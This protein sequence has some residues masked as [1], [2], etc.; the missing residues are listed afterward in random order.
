MRIVRL[1]A[2]ALTLLVCT[3]IVG[4]WGLAAQVSSANNTVVMMDNCLPGD[5]GYSAA[6]G[7]CAQRPNLGDVPAA[8]FGQLLISPLISG[9]VGHPA[10]RNEP[11]H[12]VIKRGHALRVTNRGGRTHTLTKVENS[13]AVRS[14]HSI[15]R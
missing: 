12:V 9:L 2:L 15:L 1:A 7:G 13:A 10:W 14:R 8:E 11:S 5:P 3:A 4:N 6:T